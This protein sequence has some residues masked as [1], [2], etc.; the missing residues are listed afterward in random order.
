MN[1]LLIDP[2][3]PIPPKSKN[4]CYFLPIGL[5]KIGT[6]HRQQGDKVQLIRGNVER[7]M[8]KFKPDMIMIT[9]LFTYWSKYVVDSSMHYRKLFP[10][11]KIIIGGIWASLMPEKCQ[12]LTLVD[13][14]YTGLYN[15]GT[16]ESIDIDY[17]L[18][19]NPIDYQIVHAS[20][21]CFRKCNFC[22]TWRIEKDIIYK[23]SVISEIQKNNLIFYDNNILANPNIE[24]ILGE[25]STYR[26]NK[27]MVHSEC[28]SG[29]DGRILIQK[30]HFATLLKKAHFENPRIAWDGCVG[31][32]NSIRDQIA[33]LKDSGYKANR[34]D[35]DIYVFMLFNHN[36]LYDEMCEK[37]N[38]CRKWGVLVVDCR[39]RPLD[40]LND[41]YSPRK[42]SQQDNEYYIHQGWT[43]CQ[44]RDFRRKVRQQNIAIRLALPENKYIQG[45]EKGFVLSQDHVA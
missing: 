1:I 10:K 6:F 8:I 22:G 38:Y 32:S 4:K 44:V 24:N 5:L 14:V 43:D 19:E 42:K 31:L 35:S 40:S 3:F 27:R 21:G 11:A 37:L 33:I 45:V 28:Q 30:P 7:A 34:K 29:L 12:E 13:E 26:L 15:K 39:Y 23:T 17:S 20:R 16:I 2:N 41:N 25:L 9:S 36:L 18:L